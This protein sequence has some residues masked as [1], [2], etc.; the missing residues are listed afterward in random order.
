MFASRKRESEAL[1]EGR[2]FDLREDS[3]RKNNI[4]VFRVFHSQDELPI[5]MFAL[6][7]GGRSTKTFKPKK[8]IPEG[9]HQYDLMKQAAATLGS[10]NLRMAVMLPEGEDLNEW[11][12]LWIFFNQINMLYGTITEFCSAE[13]CAV[14][15][16]GPK[17]EYHWADG[18]TIKKPIKCSAPKY[19]DYLMTWVQDQLDDEMLFPSKI[20]VPFPKN[21]LSIAKTILKRLFRVYAHI[22]YQHFLHIV[23]LGEEAHL[24]TSFKHFMFF[25]QEFSL[26]DKRELAP[27]QELIEKLTNKDKV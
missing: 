13:S 25:V 19:I 5:I 23:G 11:V 24:N 16:A 27:L 1:I 14:M 18:T 21:F 15:S 20:G 12:A 6:F 7:S 22:Y 2:H 17:Y 3:L 8:N 9:T 4:G 26:V 10:G